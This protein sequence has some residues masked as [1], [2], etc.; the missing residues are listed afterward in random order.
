MAFIDR[1]LQQPAYGWSDKTGTLVIP[2]KRQ[3]FTEA[4]SRL[5][6]LATRKNWIPAISWLMMLCLLPFAALAFFKYFSWPLLGIGFVYSI[7]IMS[8]QATIWFHRY[9]THKAYTFSHPIWRFITQNL[10]LRTF[11]EEI[12]VVSHHVH[13][14]KSDQPGDPYNAQ[15][16]LLYCMLSDV[17][18]QP[19]A[20][21]LTETDYKKAASFLRHTGIWINSYESYLTWGSI[22]SPV[23]T[24][25]LWLLNWSFWYTVFFLIGGHGLACA[26]FTGA[27][28]WFVLVRAFNYTGHGKGQQK[29]VDGVD[30]DR[31][32]LSLNQLRPGLFSGEW[33]NNHHL[34]PSSARAGFLRFQLDLAWLYILGLYKLGAVASY[35]DNKKDFLQKYVHPQ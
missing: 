11:P 24:I 15:G 28:F 30:F 1:V 14:A 25:G 17:N 13:H 20:K 26:L 19:I 31:R 32:N 16:G 34:Y 8:T 2:T 29:H 6:I 7:S 12:Y 23:H 33:H 18:H 10:V 9:S 22:A 5:N 21:D 35:R 4:F 3:L 27:L